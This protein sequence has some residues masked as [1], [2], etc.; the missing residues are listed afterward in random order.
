MRTVAIFKNRLN[1][2]IRLPKDM[3]F[4]GITELEI[5]KLGDII[6]LRPARPC[7]TSLK[8]LPPTDVDFLENRSDIIE[9]IPF[10]LSE[11]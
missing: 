4:K 6:T 11:P 5:Q 7:W 3:E 8:A 10:E 1:Q 2:A 9:D